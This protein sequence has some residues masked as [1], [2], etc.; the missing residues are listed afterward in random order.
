MGLTEDGLQ[1]LGNYEPLPTD[2]E[3]LME[4]WKDQLTPEIFKLLKYLYD[5]ADGNYMTREQVASGTGHDLTV[6][7]IRNKFTILRG[8]GL[9]DESGK[10]QMKI[11]DDFLN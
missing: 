8:L 2:G 9:I 7:T 11:A 3:S 6:S 4:Y 10:D 1:A 5:H